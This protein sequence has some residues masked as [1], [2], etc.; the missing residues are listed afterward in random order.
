MIKKILLFLTLF[1][2]IIGK[3][4]LNRIFKD[5]CLFEIN[6]IIIGLII[7]ILLLKI[8]VKPYI[9]RVNNKNLKIFLTFSIVFFLTLLSS[10]FFANDVSASLDKFKYILFELLM[11]LF[12]FIAMAQFYNTDDVGIMIGKTFVFIG[13]FYFL[14]ITFSVFILDK[15]RGE[16]F[17]GGPNVTTRILFFSAM[18]SLFLYNIYKNLIYSIFFLLML[19]G[20]IL[21]GSRSGIFSSFFC[22][23]LIF[24]GSKRLS[25]KK[26]ISYFKSKKKFVFIAICSIL[27]LFYYK[28]LYD[29]FYGRIIILTFQKLYLSGREE[30]LNYSINAIFKKPIFGYGLV[31]GYGL[32]EYS[33]PHNIFLEIILYIG[34]L[35][36]VYSA[37]IIFFSLFCFIKAKNT[38]YRCLSILPLYML[39]V[40]FFSGGI[41]DFRYYFLWVIVVLFLLTRK[42]NVQLVNR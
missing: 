36:V 3:F 24:C 34:V 29:I 5:Y 26:I 41:Y 11:I 33:Y 31:S 12:L 16:I 22:L 20:I 35:G 4:N 21:V 30:I 6:I 10:I 42:Q 17:Y 13:L 23:L 18:C 1:L 27:L 28:H 14:L 19:F 7:L 38:K 9:Y 8:S 39:F 15:T 2:F 37:I 25:I 40:S 32:R